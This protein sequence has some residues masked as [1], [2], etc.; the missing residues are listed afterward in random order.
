MVAPEVILAE[1]E[2]HLRATFA[3]QEL[4]LHDRSERHRGHGGYR[5]GVLTHLEVEMVSDHFAGTTKLERQ[6]IVHRALSEVSG[7]DLSPQSGSGSSGSSGDSGGG[8]REDLLG[9]SGLHSLS[10]VLRAPAEL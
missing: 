8:L 6:R 2:A 4:V 10:L 3:P 5:E 1:I 9:E 7:V